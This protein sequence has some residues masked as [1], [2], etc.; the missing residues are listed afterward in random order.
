MGLTVDVE[1]LPGGRLDMLSVNDASLNKKGG[2]IKPELDTVSTLALS[3]PYLPLQSLTGFSFVVFGQFDIVRI[4]L[5]FVKLDLLRVLDLVQGRVE[6]DNDLKEVV[7]GRRVLTLVMLLI[8][9]V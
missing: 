7:V 4:E 5:G 8:A 9:R 1:G 6:V 2:I 3:R